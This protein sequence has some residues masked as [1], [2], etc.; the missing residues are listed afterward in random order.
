MPSFTSGGKQI[1]LD[2]YAPAS[3]GVHPAIILV[4]G[5][6]GP[7]RSVD[8]IA[9]QAANMGAHVFAVHYLERTGHPWVYGSTIEQHF[10]EWLD[11]LRDTL[12]YVLRQPEVDKDRVALLGFSLGAYLSVTLASEDD[13]VAALVDLFGGIPK[14]ILPTVKHL[15]PTLILHGDADTVVPVSEAYVLESVLKKL[16][17]PCDIQIFSGQGHMFTG[18]AQ[19]Q[20]AAAI[21]R[22]L[23]GEFQLSGV[24]L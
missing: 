16:G 13:R 9:Q 23:A 24:G 15:P 19:F 10:P 5:S 4:H 12:D 11:T 7:L 6:G 17:V 22:F 21:A 3:K 18:V 14:H 20:A 8:P 2:H 1:R